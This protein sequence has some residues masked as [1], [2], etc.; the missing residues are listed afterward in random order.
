VPVIAIVD[1]QNTNRQIYGMLVRSLG[2]D[3]TVEAFAEPS[4]AME[5]ISSHAIDLV[6]TDYRMPEM[7]GAELTRAVR[8][9]PHC[10]STPIIVITAYDDPHFRLRALEAGATDFVQMPIRHLEF[11]S[12]VR[13]ALENAGAKASPAIRSTLVQ[14]L[15][16]GASSPLLQIDGLIQV[17]DTVPALIYITDLHGICRFV[18]ATCAKHLRMESADCIGQHISQ[19]RGQDAGSRGAL[20][21]RLVVERG[22]QLPSYE[23][24]ATDA[25]GITRTFLTTKSPLYDDDGLVISILTTSLDITNQ[26]SAQRHLE[27]LAGH[28]ALTGLPNRTLL[29]RRIEERVSVSSRLQEMGALHFL[30]LDHFKTLN[31]SLGHVF[32]DQLL[33]AIARILQGSVGPGDTVA[34]LGGDEFAILQP[35]IQDA[36]EAAALAQK[37]SDALSQPIK[38][39]GHSISV[40]CSTGI[41]IFPKDSANTDELLKNADLAM[42]RA[43][44]EGRHGHRFFS[45]DQLHGVEQDR[46]LH[47]GLREALVRGEFRL[48]YQPQVHLGTGEVASVEALLRWERPGY[49]LVPPGRFLRAAE[50]SGLIVQITEWVLQEACEQMRRW[51]DAGMAPQRMAVNVSPTLFRRQDV[52]QLVVRSAQ[53]AGIPLAALE[54]ELTEG[55]LMDRSTATLEML[56]ALRRDGVGLALDDF[57]TGFSS[58]GYLRRFKVN[59]IKIDQSFVQGLPDNP[60]D[61]T[62]VRTIIGL[63]HGLGLIAVAEGVETQEMLDFLRAHGCDEVQG[64]YLGRPCPPEDCARIILASR[65]PAA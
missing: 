39:R 12:C 8:A 50:D 30:D 35:G 43:K 7:D 56:Q 20:L 28:D 31:D 57:G 46:F 37:V 18:N 22:E 63:A 10:L 1:D 3:I 52:H 53:A 45:A 14:R 13:S 36:A 51:R 58:L 17:I 49:G 62:I 48:H 19:L 33:V 42:Y 15:G 59:R 16:R 11:Q 25:D 64:Y 61:A 47:S 60:D 26:K 5:W 21:D 32:G 55:V 65:Q 4:L 2:P 27:H 40:S 9:L 24:S 38:I 29:V 41:T 34:R 44:N 6:V 23:E 54:L